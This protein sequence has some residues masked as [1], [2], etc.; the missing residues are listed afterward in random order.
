[1]IFH[2]PNKVGLTNYILKMINLTPVE[3]LEYQKTEK[4]IEA[5]KNMLYF[6]KRIVN[7]N[8]SLHSFATL[9]IEEFN[10]PF[11]TSKFN[12]TVITTMD[13]FNDFLTKNEQYKDDVLYIALKKIKSFQEYHD[14][15]YDVD[16]NFFQLYPSYVG[17]DFFSNFFEF[18]DEQK[19]AISI[20]ED[21]VA[22]KIDSLNQQISDLEKKNNE[23]TEIAS[24]RV[25]ADAQ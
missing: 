11:L 4:Q 24:K 21:I 7:H 9:K 8:F 2:S 22:S 5:H 16:K 20:P 18:F 10:D 17:H 3:T 12:D 19:Y 14:F 23:L 25:A 1:M 13:K 15:T 6:Y